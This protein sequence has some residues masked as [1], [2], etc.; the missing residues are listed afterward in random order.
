MSVCGAK[1]RKPGSPPCKNAAVT[2][3]TR[4]RMHGGKTP[5]GAALPQTKHGRYSKDLPTH[6]GA[7]FLAAQSD[8]DLLN[9]NAEISLVDTRVGDL[10]QRVDI[11]G[12]GALWL[13]LGGIV[14]DLE[15]F[16][17]EEDMEGIEQGITRLKQ[18]IRRA[19]DDAEAWNQIYPLVEQRRKLVESEG[20]RRK[21]MQDMITSEKAM[22]LVT[23][24][25]D[26]VRKHVHDRDTLAAISA[27]LARLLEHDAG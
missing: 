15:A 23:S 27:D 17:D 7:R 6:L 21:D 11:D 25:V 12:A 10:L 2:G 9:L 19:K 4:C 14:D 8:P 26:T 3:S 20:K 5:R 13:S 1:T 22:L 16:F 18:L 24:L